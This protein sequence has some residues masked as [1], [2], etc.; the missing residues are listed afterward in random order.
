MLAYAMDN[1]APATIVLISGD[2]DFVHAVSLLRLRR[3]HVVIIAPTQNNMHLSMKHQASEVYDWCSDIISTPSR[4]GDT[5]LNPRSGNG[6]S[7]V[8]TSPA[9]ISTARSLRSSAVP[10]YPGSPAVARGER[11]NR[12]RQRRPSELDGSEESD[13]PVRMYDSVAAGF[14]FG[15]FYANISAPCTVSYMLT[16]EI[17][18]L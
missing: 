9:A 15:S 12:T 5:P 1:P 8:S 11:G 7:R 16:C 17:L 14:T 2:G 13:R 18:H 10:F 6:M 3:Y 4:V